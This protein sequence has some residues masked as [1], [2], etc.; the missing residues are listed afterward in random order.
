V[1]RRYPLRL[2]G[3]GAER[4]TLADWVGTSAAALSPLD[5]L[6]E[7]HVQAAARLHG[8]DTTVPLLARGKTVTARLWTYVRDDRP[9]A[10][11]A[12]L[13]SCS[14]SRATGRPSTRGGI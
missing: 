10:G 9:F 11:L 2:G 5:A 6:I 3:G 7:A 1:Q 8:D 13:P 4:P 12:P 14:T